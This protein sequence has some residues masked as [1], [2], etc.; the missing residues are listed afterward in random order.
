M[1]VIADVEWAQN[2][3]NKNSP[4]QLFAFRVDSQWKIIDEFSAFIRPLDDTFHD[5]NHMA[6]TGGTP[7][8]FINAHSCYNVFQSFN[9]WV[10]ED[11][12]CWWSRPSHNMH[13]FVNKY[14]LK[15]SP[16]G[17]PVILSEYMPGFLS[18]NSKKIANAYKLAK[19]QGIAAPLPEHYARN[20]IKTIVNLL[21]GIRF[22]QENLLKP[23][24]SPPSSRPT[25]ALAA[26][27]GGNLLAPPVNPP[28]TGSQALDYKYDSTN[29]IF[30][31]SYCT[32]IPEGAEIVMCAT[33]KGA[34]KNNYKPCECVKDELRLARREKITD[35]IQRSQYTFIYTEKSCV[36][37]RYDCKLVY[38]SNHILGTVKYEN[39]IKKG[40]RPCKVCKPSENDEYRPSVIQQKLNAIRTKKAARFSIGKFEKNAIKRHKQSQNE[41]YSNIQNDMTKQ[42]KEDLYTLTQP[43]FAF[44]AAKGYENF[45]TR[46]CRRLQGKSHIEGFDTFSRAR[47][48]GYTPCKTCKPTSK[49][50]ILV[51][52][53]INNKIRPFETIEKLTEL[54]TTHGYEYNISKNRLELTTPVGKWIINLSERPVTIEH[55]NLVK[56][57]DCQVYHRQPRIF[58]S[59]TDAFNYIHRHDT[60]LLNETKPDNK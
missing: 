29:N 42:E 11:I 56:T 49:Q 8:D 34:I 27:G 57:P 12:I 26:K 44:F 41:R 19:A 55:I 24:V 45:H 28:I 5:W 48:A 6:Y 53:P 3:A 17:N 20:D 7:E 43:R 54:C 23:P 16:P 22:P 15:T 33:L 58:L 36:F 13:C 47:K 38:N 31:R 59:L 4:T 40:L 60:S 35:E 46:N 10:G 32:L 50:D 30:H 52:I 51:S 1:Y 9:K 18:G 2:K 37:H 25:A 39:I 14:I 21:T